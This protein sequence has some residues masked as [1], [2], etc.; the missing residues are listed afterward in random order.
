MIPVTGSW[1]LGP[2]LG[3]NTKYV[4]TSNQQPATEDITAII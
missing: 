3:V 1:L 4:I 2:G